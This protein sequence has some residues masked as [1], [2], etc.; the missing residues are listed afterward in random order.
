MRRTLLSLSLAATL[1][2]GCSTSPQKTAEADSDTAAVVA[3][4]GTHTSENSLDWA[5]TYIGTTPCA[6][7]EGIDTELQLNEEKTYVL[8]TRY[9]GKQTPT[10]REYKGEFTWSPDGKTVTLTGLSDRPSQYAVGENMLTQL[11]MAGQRITGDNADK[12]I[13]RKK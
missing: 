4:D 13:L 6:D 12:Y 1:L 3:T 8:K 2:A 11:D 7:C 9:L 10:G 5:G